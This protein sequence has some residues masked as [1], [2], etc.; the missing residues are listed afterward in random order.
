MKKTKK[1]MTGIIAALTATTVG[2]SANTNNTQQEA[3][4]PIKTVEQAKETKTNTCGEVKLDHLYAKYPNVDIKAVENYLEKNNCKY[5]EKE[6]EA[7]IADLNK[8]GKPTS[9][10]NSYGSTFPYWLFL[11][12]N[13]SSSPI[14]N[15]SGFMNKTNSIHPTTPPKT[16]NIVKQPVTSNSGI[17]L[18]KNPNVTSG[19]HNS[20]SSSTS[21]SSSAKISKGIGSSSTHSGS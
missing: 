13:R 20:N 12:S 10:T 6:L 7:F 11:M 3:T 18:N 9:T 19:T 15:Q 14:S 17:N 8:N 4:K 5:N 2:C 16:V 1:M 21:T